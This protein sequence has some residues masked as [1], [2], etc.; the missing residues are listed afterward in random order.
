MIF[1]GSNYS[2]PRGGSLPNTQ[3]G[4]TGKL[5][6]FTRARNESVIY[7]LKAIKRSYEDRGLFVTAL[8]VRKELATEINISHQTI[9]RIVAEMGMGEALHPSQGVRYKSK[10]L[11][12][13]DFPDLVEMMRGQSVIKPEKNYHTCAW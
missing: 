5:I 12:S 9:F 8:A 11:N 10:R 13:V 6:E 1:D 3:G 7:R 4:G 2:V